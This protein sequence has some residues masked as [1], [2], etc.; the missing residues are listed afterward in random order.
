MKKLAQIVIKLRTFI[1]ITTILVTLILGYFI[2]D[3]KINP[4]IFSYLP[5]SDP[6]VKLFDYIGEKYAGN[7]LAIVAL[8]TDDV[9]SKET[10]ERINQLTNEFKLV[11][12][13]S[14]VTSLTNVLDIKKGKGGI[15]IGKL[16]D[17]YNLPQTDEELKKLKS[18]TLSKDMYRGRIV[19]EDSKATLIICRLRE[20]VDKIKIARQLKEIVKKMNLK[21]KIHYSGLP[22]QL[23][24]ISEIILNDLKFLVP[25]VS[26][27][28]IICLFFSFRNLRGVFLPIIS[29]LISTIWTLGIMSIF[30]VPLTVISD[31]IP[32]ILVAVGTAYSIHVVS[33]FDE[34][35]STIED[36]IK[37]AQNALSEV[38]IPV[39]LAG[40]TTIAGFISF[41]F[42]SYLT[43]I[44]QFGIFSSLGILFA[45]IISLTFTPS[46]LSLSSSKRKTTILS[47]N[48]SK[49]N[50]VDRFMDK[51]GEWV[52][53]NEKIIIVCAIIVVVLCFIGIP[54]IKR[55]VNMLDYFSS[56]HP[57]R[58]TEEMMEK[59]F[60]GSI[61]VQILVKGDIQ[62]PSVLKEMKKMEEFLKTQDNVHNPQSIADFIEEMNDVMGEGKTIPDSKDKVS[63]L[64][65][66]LEGEDMISQLVNP[67]KTEAVIRATLESVDTK[68]GRKLIKNIDE[69]IKKINNSSVT[70]IQADMPII[71]RNL[72]DSIINSQ[73]QSLIIAL[74]LIFICLVFLTHSITGGLVSLTPIV[75]TLLVIFGFMGFSGVPLDVATVLVG[76]ISIGIGIDY[77]IHF[78]N[79]FRKEFKEDKTELGALDKTLETTGK[80]ILINV[81][82]VMMGFLV[83]VL[84]NLVP[85][86]RFGILVALTMISSGVGSI[87]LLPAIILLS[88]AKFIG[89]FSRFITT[90]K[91]H[92]MQRLDSVIGK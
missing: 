73:V 91:N 40:V 12:G 88:K 1:V 48:F 45:L 38:G 90:A 15:E 11:D 80:A 67:E 9:F 30:K 35:L 43:A 52:L 56:K 18:Y 72:D 71:Y 53:N 16:I 84:A 78:V 79:R 26:F 34:D 17:E 39:I 61:P 20:D 31:I 70:F 28:I 58:I 65:F 68:R 41:V 19:S 33:K 75:F 81:L 14:Y 63:N 69:Y 92:L 24:D 51:I 77:S 21:E 42:G 47:E 50:S 10:I 57:I 60:G 37:A 86:R 85:L 44:S 13:V 4:D 89:D 82:T 6:A 23:M 76:S 66:L 54:K 64:F 32:V 5:K 59:K 29:V 8:E 87:T 22:F 7:Y 2:K 36:N 25:I 3:L 74:V 83:L 55:E 62:D 27:L 46:V 49:K